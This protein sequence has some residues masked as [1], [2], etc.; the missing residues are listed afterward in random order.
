R[1]E[2]YCLSDFWDYMYEEMLRSSLASIPGGYP[3]SYVEEVP[4]DEVIDQETLF[5]TSVK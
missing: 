4:E 5:V 1:Y 3:G 2:T